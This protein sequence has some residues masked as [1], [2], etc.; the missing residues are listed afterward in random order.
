MIASGPD[1]L[2]VDPEDPFPNRDE[3]YAQAQAHS[4]AVDRWLGL[5]IEKVESQLSTQPAPEGVELWAHQPPGTFLTPYSELRR[6]LEMIQ[7]QPGDLIVDVGAA[8]GRM[9]FVLGRHFPQS[10]FLG[11][12]IS[13][14]RVAEAQRVLDLH[15]HTRAT[16]QVADLSAFPIPPA[17]AHFLYDFGTRMV[18]ESALAQLRHLAQSG[19]VTV[20]GRGRL[21][22]DLIERKE[23]WLSQ[24]VPP[25]VGPRWSIYRSHG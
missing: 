20:I 5:E 16:M 18:V 23:P 25:Q 24:V 11:L 21:V 4:E 22:R 13:K 3:S 9:G 8:Y 12:E 17:R 19:P 14:V 1:G 7:P 2:R 10:Y 6:M 15:G